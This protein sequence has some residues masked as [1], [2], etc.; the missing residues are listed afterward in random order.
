M[1]FID[2]KKILKGMKL[3][4]N[5]QKLIYTTLIIYTRSPP[6][7]LLVIGNADEEPF[8]KC[9]CPNAGGS[10]LFR[11]DPSLVKRAGF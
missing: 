7:R 8:S 10:V 2:V 3:N 4:L 9:K 5:I 1:T 11:P 6:A